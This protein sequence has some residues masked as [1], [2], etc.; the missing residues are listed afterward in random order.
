MKQYK[1]IKIYYSDFNLVCYDFE[2]EK[3]TFIESNV[4]IEKIINQLNNDGYYI[5]AAYPFGANIAYILTKE[6]D[7][8]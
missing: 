8:I 1:T 5:T 7:V 6:K 4:Q 3:P 2:S